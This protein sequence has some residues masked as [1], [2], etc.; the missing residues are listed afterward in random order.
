MRPA[1]DLVMGTGLSGTSPLRVGSG[2]YPVYYSLARS[3]GRFSKRI[4]AFA[5]GSSEIP[6][7][8][9]LKSAVNE[10]EIKLRSASNI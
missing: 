7:M 10:D 4:R 8:N 3:N 1:E 5:S 9:N 2:P 6:N